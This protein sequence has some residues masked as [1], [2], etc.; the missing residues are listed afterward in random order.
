MNG[1][2]LSTAVSTRI[3]ESTIRTPET[4][5][6]AVALDALDEATWVG[7]FR[8]P[9]GVRIHGNYWD[10]HAPLVPRYPMIRIVDSGRV[11][12]VDPRLGTAEENAWLFDGFGTVLAQFCCG[13]GIQDV[14][15]REPYT[16]LTY[17]DEGVFSSVP[18][19]AEGVA[20]F[21]L[22][23]LLQFGYQSR[24]RGEA[25]DVVDC[26]AACWGSGHTVWFCPYTGF[27]IVG[28]DIDR[29]SQVVYELPKKLAGPGAIAPIRSGFIVHSPYTDKAGLFHWQ[30]GERKATRIG[31]YDSELRGISEG[32]FLG[33]GPRGYT[34][35]RCIAD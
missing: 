34:L 18:P 19:G 8:E 31:S 16:V 35:V 23:G 15:V 9:R 29:Q 26:Y 5:G 27:P 13:D 17:F 1:A 7:V 32:C 21:D 24:F 11:L 28:M 33:S 25:V 4:M 2:L 22:Q 3:E 12:M 14:L 30:P 6:P 10:F 20:V